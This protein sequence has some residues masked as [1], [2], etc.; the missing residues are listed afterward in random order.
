[1]IDGCLTEGEEIVDDKQLNQLQELQSEALSSLSI[2]PGTGAKKH[3][4]SDK[5]DK[6]C[7]YLALPSVLETVLNV[8]KLLEYY[9]LFEEKGC[10][11]SGLSVFSI[12]ET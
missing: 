3:F 8:A 7:P 11:A 6:G 2:K 5:R 1:M 12:G 4:N 10:R 9:K